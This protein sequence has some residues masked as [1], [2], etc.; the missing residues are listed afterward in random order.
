[1]TEL[2]P[3]LSQLISPRRRCQKTWS[4]STLLPTVCLARPHVRTLYHLHVRKSVTFD[5]RTLAVAS[6]R[7][8]EF[9]WQ[10]KLAKIWGVVDPV[11]NF[12]LL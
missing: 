1:M 7:A 2:S 9:V 3:N 8:S 11:K 4:K 5:A 10:K 6:D 12:P